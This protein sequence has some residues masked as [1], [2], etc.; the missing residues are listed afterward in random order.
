ME[1]HPLP[2][3]AGPGKPVLGDLIKPRL[4]V[5]EEALAELK[6]AGIDHFFHLAAVYDMTADEERNRIANVD[7][8]RNAVT[9]A[10]EIEAGRFHHV[11]LIAAAGLYKGLF[12]EDMFE[13]GQKLTHPY[14]RTKF[15][16]EKLARTQTKMPWRVYR[17]GSVVGNS[18]RRDGQDR[19]ALLLLHCDQ[20]A[21]PLSAGWFP[22]I[23]PSSATPTSSRSTSS[24][25]RSTTSPTRTDS[26][27]RPF[28]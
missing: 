11:S 4:G 13:E 7:G 5:S 26:T 17:P 12:R 21:A 15:E 18:R 9:L 14:H 10:N 3:G 2:R 25:T 16:S 20:A 19:R 8:T 27:V 22:L 28:T 23:G 6:S 1:S 24:P